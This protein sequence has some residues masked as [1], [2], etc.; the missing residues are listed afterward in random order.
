MTIALHL[1]IIL[2]FF[3]AFIIIYHEVYEYFEYKK[4]KV[5]PIKKEQIKKMI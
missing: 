4:W 5:K 2:C 1:I 3:I